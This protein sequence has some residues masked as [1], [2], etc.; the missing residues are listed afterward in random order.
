MNGLDETEND[1]D[2]DRNDIDTDTNDIDTTMNGMDETENDTYIDPAVL[3]YQQ[4]PSIL[5][6]LRSMSKIDSLVENQ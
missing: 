5:G 1:I 2:I 3:H 4:T 6:D